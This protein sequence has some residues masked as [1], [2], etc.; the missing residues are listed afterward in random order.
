MVEKAA[1]PQPG[2]PAPVYPAALRAAQLEGDVVARFVVD[3]SGRAEP[4][5]IAFPRVSHP[6]FA[7]AVRHALLQSRYVP[8]EV[9]GHSVRQLVEQR[10]LFAL[11]R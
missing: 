4:G 7:E 3:T 8:A 9:A 6:A 11:R 1:M 2:N 5:S 10:F